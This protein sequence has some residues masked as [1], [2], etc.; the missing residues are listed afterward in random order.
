M[1]SILQSAVRAEMQ[2][3]PGAADADE[4]AAQFQRAGRDLIQKQ[5]IHFD[6]RQLQTS[7]RLLCTH[8]AYFSDLLGALGYEFSVAASRGYVRLGPGDAGTGSRRGRIKKDETLVLFAM[9]IIWEEGVR[10]G[11]SDEYERIEASTAILADRFTT[12]GGGP[13]PSKARMMDM[14][15]DWAAHGIIRLGDEDKEAENTPITIT[16][17]IADIVTESMALLVL[18]FVAG[19]GAGN[20]GMEDALEYLQAH[21]DK[22]EAPPMESDDIDPQSKDFFNA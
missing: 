6:D 7:Y 10:S 18:E 14:L 16:S 4:I 20:D 13:L 11:E 21:Q 12:L 15:R 17:V 3:T 9:R 22:N 2:N 8:N 5:A 19:G 1:L